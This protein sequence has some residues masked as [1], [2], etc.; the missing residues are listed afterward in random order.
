RD[1]GR[2]HAHVGDAGLG[3]ERPQ[4][5]GRAV[6]HDDGGAHQQ[7][8]DEVVPH[9]PAGGGEPEE[10]VLGAE[11]LV[12]RQGF[13]VFEDDAAVA[14][15]D[16]LGQAGGA[17]GVDDPQGMVERDVLELHGVAAGAGQVRV[18]HARA[19]AAGGRLRVEVGD[20]DGG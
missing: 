18:G 19:Q 13:E 6:V 20:E 15:D 3:G 9:H 16:R 1:V 2:A 17:G 7:A 14:V 11:V 4:V 10:D 8:A 5:E 12:E